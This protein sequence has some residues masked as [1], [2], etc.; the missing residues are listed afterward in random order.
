MIWSRYNRLFYSRRFGYFLYNVFSNTLLEIDKAHYDALEGFRD[1]NIGCEN[2]DDGFRSI[3]REHKMLVAE[4]E[5]NRL[6]LA[7]QYR[8]NTQCFDNSRLGLTICPTLLCNFRCPYCFEHS[9]QETAVM[10]RETIERLL[11]F[12]RGY[13]EISHLSLAWYGGEPLIAFDVICDITERVR[14]LSLDFGGAALV[15]NGYLL[16]KRKCDLLN[17]LKIHSVQVTLDGPE[18]LHDQRRFLAGGRPTFQ[19]ILA[20]VNTLMDSSYEGSC[21]IRVNIDKHNIEG[22]PELHAFLQERFKGKKLSVYAGRVD[23]S[24]GHSY[25]HSCTLRVQEWS[26]FTFDMHGRGGLMPT[27]D[28]YPS[29]N[30]DSVCVG[31]THNKF[32]VGPEGELYKCWEDVGKPTM[33]IGDIYEDEPITNPELRAQYSIGTDPYSDPDCRACFVLPICGGGCANKR[34]RAKQFGE[35]GCEFCSPYKENLTDYLEGYIDTFL[36]REICASVLSSVCE[37]PDSSGYRLISPEKKAG[38]K[39]N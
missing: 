38:E 21:D 5:D 13:K 17:D 34:L 14:S 26:D 23:T 12:I 9:Q 4:G 24:L 3:L 22:F 11:D 10:T 7:R 25:D 1:R 39:R 6:L 35:K 27:G 36:S 15:T 28:F 2:F 33:V 8:R 18:K 29:C 32:V 20:N 30:I 31:T 19:R 37:K 16:D